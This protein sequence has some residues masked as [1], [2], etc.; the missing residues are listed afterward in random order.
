MRTLALAVLLAPT[1]A[2]ATPQGPQVDPKEEKSLE[3][4]VK[5]DAGDGK[6]WFRLGLLRH[7]AGQLD[8]AATAYERAIA[9]KGPVPLAAYNLATI[10]AAR[11]ELDKAFAG[12]E[13]AAQAGFANL[14]AAS[15][16][17]DIAPLR[18]DPRWAETF[19]R[20]DAAAHPCKKNPRN[21][22]F[23]FWVGEWDVK[24]PAGALLGQSS[25]QSIIESCVVYENWTGNTGYV[26]KS[27]N[28]YNPT[29]KKWQQTWV[30]GQGQALEFFGEI[31]EGSMA[32][33]GEAPGA[34]GKTQLQ[35][36]TFTP[37][38][39]GTVRQFWETSDDGGKT[40]QVAFEGIYH[41]KK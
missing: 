16:D 4:A 18:K 29:R 27:F 24:S 17:P 32:Y 34:D 19:A 33:T 35:R 13:R 7:R 26:G 9:G 1:I 8:A 36:L 40:W 41:R 30:D 5:K 2:L 37:R 6:S 28:F 21:R 14:A 3:D 25:V 31:K 38:A 39:D 23:D 11:K 15:K 22:E 10:H 20:M 12:L